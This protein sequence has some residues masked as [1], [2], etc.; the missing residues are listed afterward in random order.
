MTDAFRVRY[1]PWALVTG[2]S[3]GI[4]REFARQLAAR[5]LNVVLAARREAR[6]RALA[7]ELEEGCRV[8][9]RVVPLDLCHD[10]FL[11]ALRQATGGLDVGLLVN[12]AGFSMTGP[13]LD[14]DRDD[15]LR[16]LNLNVRAPMMLSYEYGR[17][18]RRR[19]RGGIIV[20]SSV[21]AFAGTPCWANYSATKAYD[22]AFAEALATELK[23]DGID[24]LALAPGTVRTEFLDVAG[25][26][27]GLTAMEATDVAALALSQLGRRRLV[28]PGLFWSA[29]VFATRFLPRRLN[30]AVFGRF[31]SLMSAD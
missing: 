29:G 22:L 11:E 15:M 28:V 31:I 19:G 4:G 27:E 18:M 6:L 2:A 25:L 1:G 20:V 14:G 13:F 3:S 10:N 16:L 24:V 5:G 9:C 30:S 8:A 26:N 21:S 7:A 12:A 17:A 23:P